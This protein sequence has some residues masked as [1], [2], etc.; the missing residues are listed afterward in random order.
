[1]KIQN[2]LFHYFEKV[3]TKVNYH[4]NDIIYMQEDDS[5]AVYLVIK[6][7]VRVFF[8][9]PSGEEITFD[10]VEKGRLFGESSFFQN[11]LRP[12]TVT[13]VNEVELIACNFMDLYP[14]LSE[15]P[16]LAVALM[17]LL[18]HNCDHL[19]FLLK[20]SYLY[21]R[22]E[23]VAYYL[24]SLVKH[25]NKDKNI[26]DNTIPYTHE[27]LAT[28]VGLSRVTVTKVLNEFAKKGYIINQYRKVKIIDKKGLAQLL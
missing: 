5:T 15:S 21:N 10:I 24:L 14:F 22:F 18:S 27:E 7:R 8:I 3:G 28:A 12:T 2:H 26:I 6:G 11:S 4:P 17:K 16:E 13:A 25:D 19:T 23:K 1:M 9:S 20:S